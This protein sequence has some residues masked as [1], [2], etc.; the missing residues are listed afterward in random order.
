MGKRFD[1]LQFPGHRNKV[2]TLSYDDGVV[3]DRR[4]VSLFDRYGVKCT[5]N[6]GYGVLGY[7]ADPRSVPGKKAVDISKVEKEEVAALYKN[8]EVSGHSLYHSDL[9]ALGEP[10]AMYEIVEDKAKLEGLVERPLQMFAYPFG[11]FN[12]TTKKLLK[13]AGY[14]GA[15]TVRSTHRFDLPQDPFELDPTCHHNDEK[16]MELAEDFVKMKTFKPAM[17]YVWG[18][19]YEFDGDDN[20]DVIEKLISYI[21]PHGDEIWF[22]TNGQILSYVEA[23]RMLEYSVDGSLVYNPTST[24]I[25]L[26]TAFGVEEHLKAG[27]V[28]KL[29]ETIL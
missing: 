23:Y 1:S 25:D 26:M 3:Q 14:K 17:F 27:T 9:S 21:A 5:F 20:W 19:G 12:E 18:H 29:K 24:D 28:T 11:T 15:R 16:L 4:L 22:A 6:L 7:K 8:H 13:S 10:Y 2:F